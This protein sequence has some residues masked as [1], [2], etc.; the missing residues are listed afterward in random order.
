MTDRELLLAIRRSLELLHQKADIIMTQQDD[1]NADVTSIEDGITAL[2]TAS[3]A[4]A[5]EIA[6]LRAANP[7]LDLT[8]LDAAAASLT[9]AVASVA[10]LAPAA[11]PAS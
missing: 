7:A 11:P 5:A 6:A 4:I 1:L 10:A 3:A 9:G 8:A 2:G